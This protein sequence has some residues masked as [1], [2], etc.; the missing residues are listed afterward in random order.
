MKRWRAWF[1]FVGLGATAILGGLI[2]WP[3]ELRGLGPLGLVLLF[4]F[5]G[6]VVEF[7]AAVSTPPADPVPPPGA[8]PPDG[9]VEI[10]PVAGVRTQPF[11]LDPRFGRFLALDPA[12][13]FAAARPIPTRAAPS[14]LGQVAIIALFLGR[15][16]RE[17]S[18]AEIAR[19]LEAMTKAGSWI[20][21]EAIRWEVAVNIGLADAVFVVTYGR[22]P[23]A[24]EIALVPEGDHAVPDVADASAR[25]LAGFSR[26]AARLGF[27][28]AADLTARINPRV[29]ADRPVWL[30]LPRAG[31]RS[32]AIPADL[33]D[34]PGVTLAVCYARE[35]NFPEPLAGPP[36]ADP[37]T[38]IHEILH[39]FGA[40]DKYG[41]SLASFPPKL[42]T[43]R[44]V[45][46]LHI[47]SLSRLR[48]DPLTAREIGWAAPSRCGAQEAGGRRN[49]E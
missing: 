4:G 30:L 46:C 42:V 34:L 28:D 26:A 48:V 10:V 37:I 18:E 44:D 20:E 21:R 3:P 14:L 8:R 36:F 32:F 38:F 40:T 16:G 27:A 23:E 19:A 6:A 49:A 22:E 2:A 29:A 39:L 15:E 41:V 9:L 35:A 11:S 1:W 7:L 43:E 31:G 5:V 12:A 33:T 47:E 17:W 25:A 13:E 45:M 24:V